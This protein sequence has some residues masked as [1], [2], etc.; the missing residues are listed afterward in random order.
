MDTPTQTTVRDLRRRWKPAKERLHA[1]QAEHPTNVRF[2]RACSWLQRAEV[3]A[4]G[5]DLD[6]VLAL[7][8]IARSTPCTA[9]GTRNSTSRG[10]TASAGSSSST[11]CSTSI[12]TARLPT[13]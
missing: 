8:W 7:Q 4:D 13:S 6:L 5:Q 12:Q 10:R 2:H 9:S 3:V 1:E 11:A